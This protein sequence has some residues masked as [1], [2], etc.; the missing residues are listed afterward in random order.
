MEQIVY[1]G[2]DARAA[3]MVYAAAGA[4]AFDGLKME[5][6]V[7]ERE[8]WVCMECGAKSLGKGSSCREGCT[9]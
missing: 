7:G 2:N 1:A 4:A 6:C 5:V 3:L 9:E 8:V